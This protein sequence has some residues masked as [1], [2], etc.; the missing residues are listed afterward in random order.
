M[1]GLFSEYTFMV[2]AAARIR[3]ESGVPTAISWNLGDPAYADEVI[4]GA[5]ADLLMVGRPALANPHWP[6]YAAL[7]LGH[8]APFNLL[9]NQYRYFL[10]KA[11]DVIARQGLRASAARGEPPCLTSCKLR[12]RH[13]SSLANSRRTTSGTRRGRAARP[14]SARAGP[15]RSSRSGTG[16]QR[17]GVAQC[18]VGRKRTTAGQ[19]LEPAQVRA[20]HAV[21][22]PVHRVGG[23]YG[24]EDP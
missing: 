16:R 11:K 19:R 10:N 13:G 9:P 15:P 24:M 2:P 17:S 18:R 4:R 5:Q 23:I 6:L 7:T 8:P 14:A 1:P 20:T 22:L 12:G 3:S 21:Q